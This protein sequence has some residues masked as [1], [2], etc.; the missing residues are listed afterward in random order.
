MSKSY[1]AFHARSEMMQTSG[2]FDGNFRARFEAPEALLKSLWCFEF[3]ITSTP[4]LTPKNPAKIAAADVS[5]GSRWTPNN[6]FCHLNKA[7]RGRRHDLRHFS[8]N[9]R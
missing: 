6:M 9:A 7:S 3:K 2:N 5:H 1:F 8:H 4:K